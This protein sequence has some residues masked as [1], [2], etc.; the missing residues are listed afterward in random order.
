V[1]DC[2]ILYIVDF[3]T[4]HEVVWTNDVRKCIR[5]QVR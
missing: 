1:R 3:F 4:K 2:D 5:F